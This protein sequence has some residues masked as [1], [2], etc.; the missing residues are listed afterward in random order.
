[1]CCIGPVEV[2]RCNR[3]LNL[4]RL[5]FYQKSAA[6]H[7]L[8]ISNIYLCIL[9]GLGTLANLRMYA[10]LNSTRTHEEIT[11]SSEKQP[12]WNRIRP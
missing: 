5:L 3:S 10:G 1:M 9:C 12:G 4:H 11:I 2:V 7:T 8:A 6:H